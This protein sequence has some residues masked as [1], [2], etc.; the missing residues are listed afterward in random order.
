MTNAN[1]EADAP[2]VPPAFRQQWNELVETAPKMIAA[3]AEYERLRL[4]CRG[5]VI[6]LLRAGVPRRYLVDKPFSPALLSRIR[7][8]EGLPHERQR[9]TP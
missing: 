2:P 8:R 9:R 7:N 5:L 6:A 3:H 1:D 4:Q